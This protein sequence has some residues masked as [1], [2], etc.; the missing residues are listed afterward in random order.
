MTLAGFDG[1]DLSF[2]VHGS[3][4]PEQR[5][6]AVGR[7]VSHLQKALAAIKSTLEANQ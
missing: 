6:A 1:L 2:C 3:D 4:D 5:R 7:S